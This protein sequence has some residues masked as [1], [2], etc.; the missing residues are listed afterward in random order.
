MAT[1]GTDNTYRL[2][3]TLNDS[4]VY[5]PDRNDPSIP[6]PTNTGYP[7]FRSITANFNILLRDGQTGQYLSAT[8][9]VSGQVLKLEATLTVLK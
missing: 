3:L 9:P 2:N 6:S 7:A 5:Y 1:S 4:S 8:D